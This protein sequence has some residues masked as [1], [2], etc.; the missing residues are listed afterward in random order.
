MLA[1][2]AVRAKETEKSD[3]FKLHGTKI[4]ITYGEHDVAEEYHS[5][6]FSPR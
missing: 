2:K 1:C 4:F 3:D 6:G 5:F